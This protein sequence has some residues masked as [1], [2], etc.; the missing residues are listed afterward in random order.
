[1]TRIRTFADAM[2]WCERSRSQSQLDQD[3][4]RLSKEERLVIYQFLVCFLGS[5][6][7]LILT[8][9]WIVWRALLWSLGLT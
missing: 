7:G 3:I 2:S 8:G 9:S 4:E 5:V 6:L 1:M